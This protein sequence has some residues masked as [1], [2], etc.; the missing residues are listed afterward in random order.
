M[1][2]LFQFHYLDYLNEDAKG[3]P[4]GCQEDAKRMLRGCEEDAKRIPRGSQYDNGFIRFVALMTTT[5]LL[6][7]NKKCLWPSD[8]FSEY[9]PKTAG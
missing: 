2:P 1:P 4:I 3:M 8:D 5:D 9:S 6:Y 7:S